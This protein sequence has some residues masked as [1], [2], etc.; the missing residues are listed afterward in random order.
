MPESDE[1]ISI[2]APE[3]LTLS[4]QDAFLAAV[5]H[6]LGFPPRNSVVLVGL[7]EDASGQ[8]SI[9]LTQRFDLPSLSLTPTE[10]TDLAS[11]VTGPMARCGASSV[12]LAVFADE[13]TPALGQ[14][15]AQ[16]LVDELVLALDDRGL[17]V[18]DMLYTDGASRWFYGCAT[19]EPGS[20][21]GV[22]IPDELRTMIAAEFAGAGAAMVDSR[23]SLFAQIAPNELSVAEV[24]ALLPPVQAGRDD[25]EIWRDEAIDRI[26]ELTPAEFPTPESKAWI[27]SG[28]Q[29]IRVRDTFLWDMAQP[30]T[31]PAP[32]IA[33]L[34]AAL[35]SA[36]EGYVAPVATVLAIQHW[37]TGDGARANACLDR[38]ATDDPN[39]SLAALTGT[40]IG[41]G[42]PPSTWRT[43]M[44]ALDRDEC[45]YG[46]S[47]AASVSTPSRAAS[48]PTM[49]TQTI[50]TSHV[51]PGITG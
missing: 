25:L 11:T 49:S 35:R 30:G 26:S 32:A 43:M 27:L 1:T 42:L 39:Y 47:S 13:S 29:D 9:R 36:P 14:L 17:W 33:S 3:R 50:A 37:T 44:G 34:T 22:P 20:Q 15:P 21:E 46:M 8:E 48:S 6:L 45:R 31:D 38:A 24:A 23:Q 10:L 41:H 16:G 2:A 18:K 4:S 40:A 7:T 51:S 5:P 12:I 19:Q 28:F